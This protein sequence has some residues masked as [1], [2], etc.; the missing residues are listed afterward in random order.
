MSCARVSY[1]GIAKNRVGR[2]C[3]RIQKAEIGKTLSTIGGIRNSFKTAGHAESPAWIGAEDG[4]EIVIANH[5][6]AAAPRAG[7]SVLLEPADCR[8]QRRTR[9]AND[10]PAPVAFVLS[11]G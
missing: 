7:R 9:N 8:I 3:T 2:K 4:A 6:A 5:Y 1:Q 10:V 11:R